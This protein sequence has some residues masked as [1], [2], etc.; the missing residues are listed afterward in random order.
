MISFKICVTE[1]S[2]ELTWWLGGDINREGYLCL[3][4]VRRAMPAQSVLQG[5]PLISFRILDDV[6]L[7][8]TAITV[9]YS[10]ALSVL[11]NCVLDNTD[12]GWR[13][14]PID[15]IP[16]IASYQRQ[17]RNQ[18]LEGIAIANGNASTA[19]VVEV[20]IRPHH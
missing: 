15:T 4:V 20:G 9:A 11:R 16:M 3:S 2:F 14:V 8:E 7:R 1:Q 12:L 6:R 5:L 18:K 13:Y 10:I 19:S 17:L